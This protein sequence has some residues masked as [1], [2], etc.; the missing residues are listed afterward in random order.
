MI[1]SCPALFLS[2][3]QFSVSWH[4]HGGNTKGKDQTQSPSCYNLLTAWVKHCGQGCLGLLG[5]MTW[6]LFL[7]M[8]YPVA[9]PL[10]PTF[11]W[12]S[13]S[14]LLATKTTYVFIWP[15]TVCD[16]ISSFRKTMK[17]LSSTNYLFLKM[18]FYFIEISPI[19][20]KV[21]HSKFFLTLNNELTV[22]LFYVLWRV[23]HSR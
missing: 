18:K 15:F 4:F 10:L 11:D 5:V 6:L 3:Y 9:F 1:L 17:V 2:L 22:V 23:I 13:P 7:P 16:V 21:F 20:F 12:G 19:C 14:G 8:H